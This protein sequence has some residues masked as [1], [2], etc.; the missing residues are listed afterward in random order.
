V[1]TPTIPEA[2]LGA[3]ILATALAW[4]WIGYFAW[5]WPGVAS[6]VTPLVF[7]PF[8][9]WLRWAWRAVRRERR[10]GN[11]P[12]VAEGPFE[13]PPSTTG[14][15]TMP[16][17]PPPR[18]SRKFV[19]A[20]ERVELRPPGFYTMMDP[21]CADLHYGFPY[22]PGDKEQHIASDGSEW[23]FNNLGGGEWDAVSD[24]DDDL[25]RTMAAAAEVQG[26]QAAR[27]FVKA[28]ERGELRHLDEGQE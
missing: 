3:V 19:Q 18:P 23:V 26:E 12:G 28:V 8:G 27:A 1:R 13:L 16:P 7:I 6:L 20:V 10:P 5:G 9:V 14:R 15:R 2:H 4:S 24:P 22:P 17:S 21:E 25:R 11:V